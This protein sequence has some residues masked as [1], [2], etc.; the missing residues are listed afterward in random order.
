VKGTLRT[1]AESAASRVEADWGRLEWLASGPLGNASGH[2]LGRVV[3]KKGM[4]NPRHRHSNCEESLFLMS[5]RLEHSVGDE[6]VTME[7]GDTLVVEAG[8]P[9]NAKSIGDE[10]AVMI[11]A[12]SSAERAFE[13]E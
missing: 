12:Y 4:A 5:G 1:A 3:I 2:T 9:H 8:V 6:V 13:K 10:D 7:A 11:V